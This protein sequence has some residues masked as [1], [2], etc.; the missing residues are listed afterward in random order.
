ML[1]R[2]GALTIVKEQA[3]LL[4]I[5]LKGRKINNRIKNQKPGFFPKYLIQPGFFPKYLIPI[6][7]LA[8][9]PGFFNP[10]AKTRNRVFYQN[11]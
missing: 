7:N 10:R 1:T 5:Y 6:F 4:L 8:E 3:E 2:F 11:I 9:K